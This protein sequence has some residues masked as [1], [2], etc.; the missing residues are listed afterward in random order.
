MITLLLMTAGC[1][2]TLMPALSFEATSNEVDL[3]HIELDAFDSFYDLDVVYTMEVELE[4]VYERSQ[5]ELDYETINH[6]AYEALVILWILPEDWD[7]GLVPTEALM[8]SILEVPPTLE[9]TE[10]EQ[11]V[12]RLFVAAGP[13]GE[14]MHMVLTM[15][16]DAHLEGTAVLRI[17]AW[18]PD[19]VEQPWLEAEVL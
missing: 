11:V 10:P 6:N 19:A 16:G 12:E 14:A 2:D 5:L 9:G 13:P 15:E 18:Y 3:G 8:G 1:M 4:E 7:G 17:R